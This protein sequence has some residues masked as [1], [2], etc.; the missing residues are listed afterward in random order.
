MPQS[1]CKLSS[2]IVFSTKNRERWRDSNIR[3]DVHAYLAGVLRKK[4]C[5]DVFVGGADDH[6]HISCV[7]TRKTAPADVLESLK[8]DSSKWI[9]AEW[10]GEYEGFYW[11]RGY[12]MFAV[13]PQYAGALERYIENQVEHH[14]TLSFQDEYR[15]F[16]KKYNI[17][18]DERYVW[19]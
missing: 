17:T 11:Q 19:D 1:L 5:M 4:E 8:R 15:A 9:K 3:T 16:L 12:G 6:V 2:H 18:Y 7:L 13:S 10:G 14:R